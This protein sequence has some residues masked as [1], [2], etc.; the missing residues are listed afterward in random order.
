MTTTIEPAEDDAGVYERDGKLLMYIGRVTI[1]GDTVTVVPCRG[2]TE[3]DMRN[4]RAA[5]KS[6]PT[7]TCGGTNLASACTTHVSVRVDIDTVIALPGADPFL[8]RFRTQPVASV[9][10]HPVSATEATTNPG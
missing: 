1:D 9:D 3:R 6:A 5:S 7:P 4:L 2:I 10:R 8:V